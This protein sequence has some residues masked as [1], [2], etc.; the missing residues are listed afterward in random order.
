MY[1]KGIPKVL[2]VYCTGFPMIHI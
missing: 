2:T 1:V